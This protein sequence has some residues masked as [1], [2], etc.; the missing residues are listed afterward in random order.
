[1]KKVRIIVI[2]LLMLI[3]NISCSKQNPD[4]HK[5]YVVSSFQVYSMV[6]KDIAKD[7]C[8]TDELFEKE[9]DL[10]EK[11]L[12]KKQI[13]KIQKAD[14][15]I[16][17]GFI[18]DKYKEQLEPYKEKIV[19]VK[20]MINQVKINISTEYPY[21]WLSP[22]LFKDFARGI[23]HQIIKKNPRNEEIYTKALKK[24]L[25]ETDSLIS[26]IIEHKISN[27]VT[28]TNELIYFSD[29][30]KS[31]NMFSEKSEEHAGQSISTLDQVGKI[32]IDVFGKEKYKNSSDYLLQIFNN[33]FIKRD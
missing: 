3:V 31:N 2:L 5:I 20:S 21:Y 27:Q 24:V 7:D 19:Y 12:S 11:E 30:L 6:V 25:T 28:I 1:M 33:V 8:K 13:K 14:L 10:K 26:N 23:N 29:F 9:Q 18:E 22:D 15:V 4:T 17:N 32:K 16:L